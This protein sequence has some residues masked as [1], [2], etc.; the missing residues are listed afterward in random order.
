M[1][2]YNNQIK[3]TM[4]RKSFLTLGGSLIAAGSLKS[5]HTNILDSTFANNADINWEMI[6]TLFPL[7]RDVVFLNNGTM[8]VTPYAVLETVQDE[9]QRIAETAQYPH[10][11]DELESLLAKTIRADAN[12]I[13]ITKNVSEGI[14]HICWGIDLKKGDEVILTK[15]EHVGGCAAWLYRAKKD[16]I[17]IKTFDLASTAAQTLANLN[18][19][20]TKKTK[21]IAVPH[22]PCT[23]G[24][25]LPVKEICSLAKSK[26][27]VSCI[28]G[29][30]PLGMLQFNVKDIGCDYYAGCLHKWMLGPIGTGWMYI[31][32]D[33]LAETKITHVAAY[34]MD[35]FNMNANPPQL[36]DLIDKTSRYCYGTFS[37]PLFKGALKSLQIYHQIGGQ[38]IENRVKFLGGYL[39]NSLLEIGDGIEMLTPTE[40]S[41]RA[42]QI[43]FKINPSKTKKGKPNIGFANYARSKGM[44]LRHV[45]EN[46]IDCIRVSTHYYN[47]TEEVDLC[48]KLLK[49]YAFG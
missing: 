25:V 29:A 7:K 39:Q 33:L 48:I 19:A 21:V 2:W 41:S 28:D 15:H 10:H 11:T 22:I 49:E 12:E 16:G 23:I 38:N 36:G 8:G 31:R 24:Q 42:A 32:K 14:N 40:S 4:H 20:I 30:H 43:G 35:T 13:A 3:P 27:I 18:A 26:N 9:F 6:R 45:G 44:I 47:T 1:N 46:D 5:L 37:G 34:S 17:I